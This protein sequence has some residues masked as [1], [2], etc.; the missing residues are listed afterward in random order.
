MNSNIQQID[1]CKKL[2]KDFWSCININKNK[3]SV[4]IN[5]G[6]EFFILSECMKKIK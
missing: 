3:S 5:C 2:S 4:K 6:Q 1:K